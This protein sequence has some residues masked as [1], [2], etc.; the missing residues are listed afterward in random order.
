MRIQGC[1]P[2]ESPVQEA[3]VAISAFT[4]LLSTSLPEELRGASEGLLFDILFG[5]FVPNDTESN[6]PLIPSLGSG[7]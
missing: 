3:T 1:R 2:P 5:E 7:K 6:D 4:N